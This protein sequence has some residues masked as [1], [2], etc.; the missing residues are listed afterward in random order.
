MNNIIKLSLQD[1]DSVNTENYS[2]KYRIERSA[3]E[4]GGKLK[5]K[6]Q[7]IATPLTPPR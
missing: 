4:N 2:D 5:K 1:Y 7:C 6:I 3:S